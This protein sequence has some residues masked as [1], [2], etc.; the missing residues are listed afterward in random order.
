MNARLEIAQFETDFDRDRFTAYV[1]VNEERWAEA[2]AL[3]FAATPALMIGLRSDYQNTREATMGVLEKSNDP[4]LPALLE[5]AL[6]MGGEWYAREAPAKLLGKIGNA[7]S[8]PALDK[9]AG[10]MGYGMDS[11]VVKAALAAAIAIRSR[12]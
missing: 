8:L 4:A 11:Y 12:I 6:G 5:N 2:A 10:G 9:T 3:G 7:A 1:Y